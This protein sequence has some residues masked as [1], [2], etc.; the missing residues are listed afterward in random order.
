MRETPKQVELSHF[1]TG[2]GTPG[3]MSP[4]NIK[5][6]IHL[7]AQQRMLHEQR[8]SRLDSAPE[9]VDDQEA[10][11]GVVV[12]R[13]EEHTSHQGEEHTSYHPFFYFFIRT[14]SSCYNE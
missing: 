3:V 10:A 2:R 11:A 14:V 9:R 5:A 12:R 13:C 4:I 7:T 1:R 6:P 8:A